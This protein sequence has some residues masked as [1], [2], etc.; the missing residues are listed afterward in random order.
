MIA[1]MIG[2]EAMSYHE[3]LSKVLASA[4]GLRPAT[5]SIDP[6][7]TLKAPFDAL[8]TDILDIEHI[9]EKFAHLTS[10][11]PYTLKG[12]GKFEDRVVYMNVEAPRETVEFI[13]D[14]KNELKQVLWLEFK[15]H[16]RNTVLHATLCYPH[17][18]AQAEEILSRLTGHVSREFH[19]TLDTIALL[20]KGDRRWEVAK[21]FLLND[22]V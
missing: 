19:A 17:H 15:P 5:A 8:S 1:H 14:L 10:P 6:H 20:K 11:V 22:L 18:A 12:F 9:I 21:T 13:E 3:N 16:E 7:L 2:G 4:Y